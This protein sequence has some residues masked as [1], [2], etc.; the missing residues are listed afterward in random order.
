MP[1]LAPHLHTD[2][3]NKLIQELFECENR[4]PYKRIIGACNLQYA[5]MQR[6]LVKELEHNRKLNHEK[7]KER[8][9]RQRAISNST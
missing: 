4:H 2:E 3:C 6:C 5:K 1:N 7:A 9:K 8:I